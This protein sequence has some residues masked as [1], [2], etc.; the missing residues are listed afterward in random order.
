MVERQEA[1]QK[2]KKRRRSGV[3]PEEQSIEDGGSGGETRVATNEETLANNDEPSSPSFL[4]AS[5]TS[6]SLFLARIASRE[7]EDDQSLVLASQSSRLTVHEEEDSFDVLSE[8]EVTATEAVCPSL[9]LPVRSRVG[10]LDECR[11]VGRLEEF[12]ATMLGQCPNFEMAVAVSSPQIHSSSIEHCEFEELETVSLNDTTGSF[13]DSE[14]DLSGFATESEETVQPGAQMTPPV[15]VMACTGCPSDS[16]L[17]E[18]LDSQLAGILMP[19]SDP[20]DQLEAVEH[21]QPVTGSRASPL[22]CGDSPSDWQWEETTLS[23]PASC[24]RS[25]L[26]PTC[27]AAVA[28]ATPAQQ[29]PSVESLS[30]GITEEDLRWD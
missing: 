27:P 19:S 28:M 16:D 13:T 10:L 21:T 7:R 24:S 12:S 11:P 3:S 20:F 23:L 4:L 8:L 5:G 14:M 9:S 17:D 1:S 26:D 18:G 15:R 22:S 2:P 29:V 25:M 6:Q 30:C